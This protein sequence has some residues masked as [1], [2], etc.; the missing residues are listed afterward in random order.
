VT[1]RYTFTRKLGAFGKVFVVRNLID[2]RVYAMKV[3]FSLD[4]LNEVGHFEK[5]DQEE[6]SCDVHSF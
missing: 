1:I 6:E 2:K 3:L 4:H 5:I